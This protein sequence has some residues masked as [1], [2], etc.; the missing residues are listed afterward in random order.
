MCDTD[1]GDPYIQKASVIPKKNHTTTEGIRVK[2]FET[3]AVAVSKANPGVDKAAV[4]EI[5]HSSVY[6]GSFFS[7]FARRGH[8]CAKPA[9]GHTAT[10]A[11]RNVATDRGRCLVCAAHRYVSLY[12][13]AV[14]VTGIT[15]AQGKSLSLFQLVRFRS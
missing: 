7:Q 6:C 11:S 15:C 1:T 13:L 10:L 8:C 14:M 3:M 4:A 5:V 2:V 12:M 9:F